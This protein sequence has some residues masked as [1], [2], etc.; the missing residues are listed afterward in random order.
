MV[1]LNIMLTKGWAETEGRS[2]FS[3][4]RDTASVQRLRLNR[5]DLYDLLLHGGYGQ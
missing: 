5:T 1:R 2:N 3:M 4:R